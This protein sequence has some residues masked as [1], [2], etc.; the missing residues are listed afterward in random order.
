MLAPVDG[1]TISL[2][3]M[4]AER[5]HLV[6]MV[7]ALSFIFLVLGA[8]NTLVLILLFPANGMIN[9]VAGLSQ[10][11]TGGISYWLIT[12][13]RRLVPPEAI[14]FVLGLVAVEGSA[15]CA[16]FLP[17]EAGLMV[18]LVATAIIAAALFIPWSTR[19]H[20]LWL[21]ACFG[22]TAVLY[23]A[24]ASYSHF[25]FLTR[26][27]LGFFFTTATASALSLCG[28]LITRR[29]RLTNLEREL[30]VRALHNQLRMVSLIDPT[31][32]IGSRLALEQTLVRLQRNSDKHCAVVMLDV[33]RF[34]LYN[35]SHDHVDGDAV[36]SKVGA[37]LAGAIRHSDYIFRYGGEEFLALLPNTTI[38][39]ARLVAERLR[40]SVEDLGIIHSALGEGAL[41]TIS[42][43]VADLNSESRDQI[44]ADL[45]RADKALYTAKNAGRNRV[46]DINH[47]E[48]EVA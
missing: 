8:V 28:H 48:A 46:F 10:T 42:A 14:A 6:T 39:E 38:P 18:G 2:R 44:L 20:L 30:Q 47:L 22:L 31:C 5:R 27:E 34:K 9:M 23:L 7:K 21:T 33:D 12:K 40:A 32:G 24:S 19:L 41:L 43:G 26:L 45:K 17:D 37:A 3:F 16:A 11:V 36:L 1:R 25:D 35:D 29:Q 13:H 4:A 15:V